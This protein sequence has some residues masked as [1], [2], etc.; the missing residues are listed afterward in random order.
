[1]KTMQQSKKMLA[2]TLA[3]LITIQ[4]ATAATELTGDVRLACE[5]TLCL[6]SS[7]RPGE[8]HPSLQRYFGIN[9]KKWKD[10]VRARR[11]FLRL[12]PASNA[13]QQMQNL[14]DTIA[15]S[16]GRCS[17]AEL[18]QSLAFS[19]PENETAISNRMP[20]YCNAWFEHAY[21][22]AAAEL[23]PLYIGTPQT[24]GFWVEPQN[25]ESELKR[26]IASVQNSSRTTTD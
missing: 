13:D 9:K 15:S 14:T 12:C 17:A 10:T 2:L 6:A 1:M 25:H 11:D 20:T 7:K 3:A 8:C 24:G 22:E 5:A 4:P 26:H 16:A 21:T 18:N 23:K 19:S